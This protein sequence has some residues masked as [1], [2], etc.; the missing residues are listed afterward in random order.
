VDGEQ[1]E[2]ML[3][4]IM[5]WAHSRTD[6]LALA[7]VGSRARGDARPDSDVDLVLLASEPQAFRHDETW[8][9]EI[10]WRN[11]G[12]VH[13]HDA[14]YGAAWSRH[15]EVDNGEI[16]FAFAG[17]AWAAV[18]PVDAGTAR[19]ISDGCRIL[20]DKTNLLRNLLTAH[21]HV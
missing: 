14:D 13:Q 5:A 4:L 16:E 8:P 9:G 20:V 6:I 15:I 12:V 21:S 10:A 2:K 17:E 7:L 18:D 3:A 19:V 1:L 11:G